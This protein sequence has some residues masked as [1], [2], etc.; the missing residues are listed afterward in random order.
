MAVSSES[1]LK[2]EELLKLNIYHCS[3]SPD[4]SL[5]EAKVN[6]MLIFFPLSLKK[7]A[8][9]CE[10]NHIKIESRLSNYLSSFKV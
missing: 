4:T 7:N 2:K 9:S 3:P 5:A 6:Q 1:V 8:F 10:K